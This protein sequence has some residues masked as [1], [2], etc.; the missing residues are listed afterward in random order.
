MLFS[1]LVSL[2]WFPSGSFLLILACH[3]YAMSLAKSNVHA[4]LEGS[5]K[6]RNHFEFWLKVHLGLLRL[7][8]PLRMGPTDCEINCGTEAPARPA[9]RHVCWYHV[10]ACMGDRRAIRPISGGDALASI[11]GR[12]STEGMGRLVA[13]AEQA[14]WPN[15]S[16]PE[17]GIAGLSPAGVISLG[18][19]TSTRGAGDAVEI[20]AS[21]RLVLRPGRADHASKRQRT[22]ECDP[23]AASCGCG[24]VIARRAGHNGSGCGV[25]PIGPHRVGHA[26]SAPEP[27]ATDVALGRYGPPLTI[28]GD[29]R[30]VWCAT[31]HRCS[32]GATQFGTVLLL[33]SS[34]LRQALRHAPQPL[35]GWP[36]AALRRRQSIVA[37][38]MQHK[39]I[40]SSH[41]LPG[42]E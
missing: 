2:V 31:S 3:V 21:P 15:E 38:A 19:R 20:F 10:H 40:H 25:P 29:G 4:S 28:D 36:P 7:R 35:G 11:W 42:W 13:L 33:V 24:P 30:A 1:F 9:W 18:N 32:P 23:R 26:P 17:P 16:L 22:V 14:P 6:H 8:A 5:V 34:L 27:P 37:H 12:I 39:Q 41:G